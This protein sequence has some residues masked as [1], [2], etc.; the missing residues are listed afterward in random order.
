MNDNVNNFVNNLE[1]DEEV[2]FDYVAEN[3]TIKKAE[4]LTLFSLE[5]SDKQYAMCSLPADDGNFDITAFIVNTLPDNT[6]S[7]D[8][9]ESEEELNLVTEAVNAIME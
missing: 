7:L 4:V 9:I 5:G 3:G 8:D 2:F 1:N 6:V